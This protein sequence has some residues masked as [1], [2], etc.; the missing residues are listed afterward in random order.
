MGWTASIAASARHVGVVIDQQKEPSAMD[1]TTVEIGL[2][3]SVFQL[4]GVNALQ[5]RL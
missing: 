3:K 1:V 2:A 4:H 5:G